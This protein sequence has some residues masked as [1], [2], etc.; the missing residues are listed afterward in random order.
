MARACTQPYTYKYRRTQRTTRI[1]KGFESGSWGSRRI[2]GGEK[3]ELDLMPATKNIVTCLEI[4]GLGLILMIFSYLWRIRYEVE[5]YR[6]YKVDETKGFKKYIWILGLLAVALVFKLILAAYYKGFEVDMNCFYS[7]SDT[8][9]DGGIGN[10]Y[11]SGGFADYPPG[12]MLILYVVEAISRLF[13]IETATV[14]SRVMIKLVP[15]LCDLGAG[16]VIWKIAKKKFS[17]GSSCLIAGLYVIAPAILM[18]S[19]VWGQTD[20]VFTLCLVLVCYLCMK[21]KRIPAYFVFMLGFFIKPQMLMFTPVL[22]WTIVEQVF[23]KDFS[24]KKFATDLI[25]GLA[26]IGA[27]LVALLPFGIGEV[28]GQYI[29]TM[30]EYEYATVNAYNFWALMGKNWVDQNEVFM[31]LPMRVWGTVIILLSVILSAYVFFKLRKR[32]DKSRYFLSGAVV[33]GTMFL[34]SVR[35]H[36][37]YLFPIMVLLLVAF[38]IR[39]ARELYAT[40]VG[41]AFAQFLNVAHVYK[42]YAVEG[43]SSGF[44]GVICIITLCVYGYMWFAIFRE[45]D[46]LPF[47]ESI[48]STGR[49]T[50]QTFISVKDEDAPKEREPRRHFHIRKTREMPKFTKM[51][52]IVLF[53]IILFYGTIAIVNLGDMHVPETEYTFTQDQ[54]VVFDLGEIKR[55]NMIYMY[56]GHYEGRRFN[57]DISQ[58]GENYESFGEMKSDTVFHWNRL[59]K[60]GENPEN[61]NLLNEY[62]YIKIKALDY[63]AYIREIAIVGEGNQVITPVN[64]GQYPELFDEQDTLEEPVTWRSGTYF[65]EIYHARTAQE[66]IDGEYCYENT[67]PPLG[68]WFMSL[69]IRVFGMNPFGWRIVGTLFG[70]GMLPFLFLFARRLFGA[71][72]WAAGVATTLFAFDFMHF[73]QTRIATIDVYGTFFIIAMFFFMYW[74]SQMSFYDTPLWKT[75]IPL[76]GAAVSMGLG[77]ASKW[78]AV[79]AAAGMAIFFFSVVYMRT[80]EY[81]FAKKDPTGVSDGIEHQHIIDVWKKNLLITFGVC[82]LLFIVLA[83]LIYLLS[84]IPFSNGDDSMGL[85]DRMIKNQVDMYNYHA[86]L[87]ADH[88]YASVWYEWPLMIRPV[89]YYSGTTLS[90]LKE[91]ISAFGNPLVWWA[92]VPAFIYLVYRIF[93]YNDGKAMFLSFAYIVQLAPW[94][95]VTRCTFMYHYFPSVPFIVLMIVYVM[96]ILDKKEDKHWRRWIFVYTGLAVLLFFYFY[97]VISGVSVD[98]NMIKDGMKWMPDW[99]L[100]I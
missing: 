90:G 40:F 39:P 73:T 99:A 21:E 55:V 81:R 59:T 68:K 9:F 64:A 91:A 75:F 12:Y 29:S 76:L 92:G 53:S 48:K 97:P 30:G 27:F 33:I 50:I 89:F 6:R 3:M 74:Y 93:R 26:S 66:M 86:N 44:I 23:L 69:G 13:S 17:E 8:I 51:D 46:T 35:M 34:F 71:K 41:F 10:F 43:S 7:W 70:I 19:S 24:W 95:F 61:Y 60:E 15:I 18:N 85:W 14:A 94:L 100:Y 79:Y 36:E 38:V 2:T 22:I 96:Y 25:G 65:D 5:G 31:F 63:D 62:R 72:T 98:G 49:K 56:N 4:G 37:R 16:F 84:Y 58:D 83:G 82:V 77:C 67:H 54:E 52:W 57:V 42:V 20:S 88:P 87:V 32:E 47:V 45:G 28:L 80:R 1:P 11:T 78:T